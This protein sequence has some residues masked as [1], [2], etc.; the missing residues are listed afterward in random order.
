M[1]QQ[2]TEWFQQLSD[3]VTQKATIRPLDHFNVMV[4]QK[5]TKDWFQ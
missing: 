2:T 1:K 4:E 3:A 5:V